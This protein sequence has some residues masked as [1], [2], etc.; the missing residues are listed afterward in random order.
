MKGLAQ[1]RFI[2]SFRQAWRLKTDHEN[3]LDGHS[4]GGNRGMEAKW[5]GLAKTKQEII[6]CFW[7]GNPRDSRYKSLSNCTVVKKKNN[8]KKKKKKKKRISDLGSTYEQ[9]IN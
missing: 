1:D 9:H 5:E 2:V 7:T 4:E 3:G 8:M 6:E